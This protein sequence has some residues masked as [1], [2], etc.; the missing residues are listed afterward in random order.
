[1]IVAP[2][3]AGYMPRRTVYHHTAYP[4]MIAA[5]AVTA[6]QAARIVK[7]NKQQAQAF[8]DWTPGADSWSTILN[9]TY[10]LACFLNNNNQSLRSFIYKF[11]TKII[12]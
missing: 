9:Q 3:G 11:Q 10:L 6:A 8:K 1:M 5:Q 7:G 4:Q 12:S 2:A